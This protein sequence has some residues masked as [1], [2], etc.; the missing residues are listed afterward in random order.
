MRKKCTGRASRDGFFKQGIGNLDFLL[1]VLFTLLDPVA[2]AL[3]VD[4]SAM[5]QH[6][7]KDSGSNGDVSEDVVP[8]GEGLV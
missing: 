4:N 7:V 5:V 3:N 2:L 8:L 6:A 1:H